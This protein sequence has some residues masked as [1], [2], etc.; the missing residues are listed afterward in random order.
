MAEQNNKFAKRKLQSSFITTIVSISLVLFMVGLLGLLVLQSKKL[1]DFVKENIQLSVILKDHAKEAEVE[2]FQKMLDASG[3]VKSTE[4]ISKDKAARDLQEELGEDFV[5]FIGY[6]PLLSSIDVRLKADYANT[7]SLR[8]IEKKLLKYKF[9]KEVF[10]QK[11]L[12]DL[13]NENLQSIGWG[14]LGISSLLGFISIVLINNTIRL[15]LYSKRFLIKTMQLVG[16]TKGF[17]RRPFL[18]RSMIN[19]I[20]GSVIACALLMGLIYFIQVEFPEVIEVNDL[21]NF[22]ILFGGVTMAGILISVLSTFFSVK[23]YL[24]MKLDDLYF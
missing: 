7:A 21:F 11:S 9:V 4:F 18:L 23:K 5:N 22:L 1:S 20:Y 2:Q 10:Y 8:E 12:V 6:N 3:F 15:S 17:I 14:I 24:R 19:G 13:V 16:A